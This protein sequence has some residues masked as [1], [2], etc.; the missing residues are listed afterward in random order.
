MRYLVGRSTL[1]IWAL[2]YI[3]SGVAVGWQVGLHNPCL[4]YQHTARASQTITISPVGNRISEAVSEEDVGRAFIQIL[5]AN[6]SHVL[7]LS[8]LPAVV[9]LPSA[10]VFGESA[11]WQAGLS[12]SDMS[13]GNKITPLIFLEIIVVYT[14][15]VFGGLRV[16][17]SVCWPAGA[18]CTSRLQGYV[19]AIRDLALCTFAIVCSLALAGI[20]EALVLIYW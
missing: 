7:F 5:A 3:L 17:L 16:F 6:F 14:L 9:C 4:A 12:L 15:A 19:R 8:I 10:L 11:A 20:Y 18:G 1:F 13:P 2:W